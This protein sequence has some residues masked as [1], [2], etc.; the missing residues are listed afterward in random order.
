MFVACTFA[1]VCVIMLTVT[2][3]YKCPFASYTEGFLNIISSCFVL[4]IPKTLFMT[5][6]TFDSAS[7]CFGYPE[8]DIFLH[9]RLPGG[10]QGYDSTYIII[11]VP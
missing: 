6:A 10:V 9:F 3:L 7:V 5:A 8:E 11:D 1:N 2:D 4:F